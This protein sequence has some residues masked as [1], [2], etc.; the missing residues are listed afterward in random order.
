MKWPGS[1][2]DDERRYARR[3][4]SWVAN[5]VFT[6]G[7]EGLEALARLR[8]QERR[9]RPVQAPYRRIERQLNVQEEANEHGT[10]REG[11]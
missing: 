6:P 7:I 10:E 2:T 5:C 8:R 3:I 1:R 9:R 11:S 4:E